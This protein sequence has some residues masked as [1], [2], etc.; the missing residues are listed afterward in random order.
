MPPGPGPDHPFH[1]RGP[2]TR[3]SIADLRRRRAS[4][5]TRWTEL[6]GRR[7]HSRVS[8]LDVPASRPE[9]VLVHGLGMSS[10]SMVPTMTRLA[11]THRVH[12]VD[13]PGSGRSDRPRRQLDTRDLSAA[14]TSWLDR[15]GLDQP[16]L[17]GSS[18]AAQLIA[19][20]PDPIAHMCGAV[21]IGPTHDP[22]APRARDQVLRLAADIRFE[23]PTLV[24]V[25]A[26]D[27]AR[28][29]PRHV[30]RS[31]RRS[32]D[33]P[34]AAVEADL[35][36]L[37]VPV[38]V[39][40]GQHDPVCSPSW[41]RTVAAVLPQGLLVTVPGSAHGMSFSAPELLVPVLRGFLDTLAPGSPDQR[42]L[43]RPLE[44]RVDCPPRR[45]PR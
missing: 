20:V 43:G 15:A 24:A 23:S 10:V 29:G 4:I 38:L 21:L 41:A 25:A 39:V 9:V 35:R 19:A 26:L 36:G 45:R 30:W 28:A 31:L 17:V 14:L 44:H 16:V 6:D 42:R 8:L 13:L 18:Y 2:A 27:Y 1:H 5:G 32:V 37:D 34:A 33:E 7:V 40:R 11:P 12:A 22:A 3:P